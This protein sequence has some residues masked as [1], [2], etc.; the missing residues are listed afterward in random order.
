MS[1]TVPTHRAWEPEPLLNGEG[2][3]L[4]SLDASTRGLIEVLRG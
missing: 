2:D 3:N 4:D 1:E